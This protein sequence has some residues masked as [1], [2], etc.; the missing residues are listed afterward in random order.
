MARISTMGLQRVLGLVVL[1][2]LMVLI[3]LINL[4]SLLDSNDARI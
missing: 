2:V 3:V 1:G 4:T